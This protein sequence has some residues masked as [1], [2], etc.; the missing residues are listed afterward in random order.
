MHISAEVID[1]HLL[2]PPRKAD[3]TN[4]IK[5]TE[6]QVGGGEMVWSPDSTRIAFVSRHDGN[7]EIYV[8]DADANDYSPVWSP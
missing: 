1:P 5:L 4:P 3:G 7:A 8:I 2:I 6:Y